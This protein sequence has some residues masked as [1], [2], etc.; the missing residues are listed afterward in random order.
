MIAFALRHNLFLVSL[1]F[2]ITVR[3][4]EQLIFTNKI[5]SKH[6][7]KPNGGY[8]VYVLYH[9]GRIDSNEGKLCLRLKLIR[10]A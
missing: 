5:I 10:A 6:I 2:Q 1:C 9:F 4:S 8:H 7:F 3:F